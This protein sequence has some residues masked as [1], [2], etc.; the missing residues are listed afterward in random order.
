MVLTLLGNYV[1][2]RTVE[3]IRA[4]SRAPIVCWCQDSMGTMGRQYLIGSRFDHV[5][6]KD[7][8]LVDK[9]KRYTRVKS[10][11]YLPEACN[12]AVHRRP[13]I[14]SSDLQRFRCDV[15]TAGT[16][17]YFRAEILEALEGCDLKIWGSMP[18]Y[19]RGALRGKHAGGSVFMRDKAACFNVAK[20]VVNSLHPIEAGG[21]N[22]RTFEVAGCGGF[23]LMT[24]SSA[25]GRYFAPG[26]EIELFE[27]LHDLREKVRYY[28]A[29]DAARAEIAQAGQR[30]AHSEH[31]YARRLAELMAHVFPD[32][33]P[34]G[35][36]AS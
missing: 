23:Q 16:L 10:V 5:F 22:A 11:H 2:P 28:L 19:Y 4:A 14:T 31:T 12:P 33:R 8:V 25:I 36:A 30:R 32:W 34:D 27:D 24:A 3:L 9:L 7:P 1:P 35:R 15:T 17:Y 29:N 20:I 13:E 26:A 6:A 21:V 18:R